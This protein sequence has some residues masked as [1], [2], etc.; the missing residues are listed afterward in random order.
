[1]EQQNAEVKQ[2]KEIKLSKA[3]FLW[4]L[5]IGVLVFLGIVLN[6]YYKDVAWALRLSGWIILSCLLVFLLYMTRE[7]K[8]LFN[9]AKESRIELSKVVWA[10]RQE[11]VHTTMIVVALVVVMSLIMWGMDSILLWL[12]GMISK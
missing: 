10:T 3:N 11:T 2:L 5:A 1:M 12:I 8:R 7:G 4:W 9:F 6:N